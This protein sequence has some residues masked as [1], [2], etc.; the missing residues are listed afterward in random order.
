MEFILK[1][2]ISQLNKLADMLKIFCAENDLPDNILF[3]LNLSLD[4][5]VTNI[6][7]YGFDDNKEHDINISV[8]KIENGVEIK[9]E[10][11]GAEFNPLNENDPKIGA[12]LEEMEV[13]GLGIY[14]VKNKMDEI[15][16]QRQLGKNIIKLK[17]KL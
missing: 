15:H 7:S 14:F 4:E 12:A 17:K 3:D 11:D 2:K 10:D 9:L 5:L 16:Y 8:E 1:N 6:I 13:G